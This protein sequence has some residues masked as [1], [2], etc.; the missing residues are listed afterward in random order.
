[1]LSA[2]SL[3]GGP[4]SGQT[5][6]TTSAQRVTSL[7]SGRGST[8]WVSFRKPDPT[9]LRQSSAGTRDER[10]GP[11]WHAAVVPGSLVGVP[12]YDATVQ[13][14]WY[15]KRFSLSDVPKVR[16][17]LRLGRIDD[18]DRSYLNG[19]LIGT[20]GNFGAKLAQA[21]DRIRLYE[22]PDELLRSPG[23]VNTIVVHVQGF[24]AG[25]NGMVIGRTELGPLRTLA[26]ELRDEDYREMLFLVAYFTAGS[27]F[28]FLFLRRGAGRENLLF[29]IFV[30]GLVVRQLVRTQLRFDFDF[31]FVALKRIEFFLTYALFPVFLYFVRSYFH[32]PKRWFVR[33][34]DLVMLAASLTLLAFIVHVL[35]SDDLAAWWWVQKTY[36]QKIWMLMLLGC[37]VIQ[38]LGGVYGNFDAWFMLGG[39]LFLVIGFV[40]DL[41]VS[42]TIIN[43]PSMFAYLF[44]AFVFSLATILA[45]R[46]VRLHNEVADLNANLER[47]VRDRTE[48]LNST[49]QAVRSL[50]EQ[51]DGDY[52]LT[53]LLMDPLGGNHASSH[54]LSIGRLILQKKRFRFRK[55]ESEI[56]GDL[57]ALYDVQ[58]RGEKFTV[59]INADAMGKSMQGAGGA[60]VVG[61]VFKSVVNR[62]QV[63]SSAADRSPEQWLKECYL[64]LQS[65]FVS[66]DGHMLVSA[67]IGLVQDSTGMLYYINAEH[68]PVVLYRHRTASY[69]ADAGDTLRK[70]GVDDDQT[71]LRVIGFRLQPDDVL[72]VGSDGRD[73]L[74]MGEDE[75]GNRIISSDD[76]L[77]L[78]LTERGAG[79]LREIVDE[80]FRIGQQTDDLSLLRLAYREDAPTASEQG[81]ALPASLEELLKADD[82][83]G[84]YDVVQSYLANNNTA[85]ARRL[86]ANLAA[87]LGRP[88]EAAIH[89]GEHARLAPERAELLFSCSLAF[90]KSGNLPVAVE[91]G[92]RCALRLP[93]HA[94][95]LVNLA[96]CHRLLGNLTRANFLNRLAL[97]RE[98]ELA[99]ARQLAELLAT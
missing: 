71:P 81:V 1:M 27:Y 75:R 8:W 95:N 72:I 33:A 43:M 76:Q 79:M 65:V 90:K 66:F 74:M 59:F 63:V 6:Q 57:I 86:A 22:V 12:G 47:K 35:V 56:G 39:M 91:Y 78:S 30:Y 98:P 62:T 53:S 55:W 14:M 87:R 70:L 64:E 21:Y 18:R 40:T 54:E 36:G 31:G 4:Q 84:A 61:T 67:V 42:L 73:D 83:A 99:A 88:E 77:F 69:L 15:L 20:T 2:S 94:R 25:E 32:L 9:L 68:P 52:F 19:K 17:A 50:K 37:V 29:A 11:D 16:L 3:L 46:F 96:D 93:E 80:A 58:L 48:K 34:I 23:Q 85:E 28:L 44:A 41:L 82:H 24:S 49:L 10:P 97:Q 92:E 38:V 5:I 89:K 45:N 7:D 26:N 51:Q 13:E 60:I